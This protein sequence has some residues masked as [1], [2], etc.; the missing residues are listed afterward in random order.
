MKVELNPGDRLEICFFEADGLFV[1]TYGPADLT[2]YSE[3]PG[4]RVGGEGV[5]YHEHYGLSPEQEAERAELLKGIPAE[6]PDECSD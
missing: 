5:I 6:D 2:I 4:N 3:F 1:V